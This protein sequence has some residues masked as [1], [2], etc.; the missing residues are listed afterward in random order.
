MQTLAEHPHPIVTVT[1][2]KEADGKGPEGPDTAGQTAEPPADAPAAAVEVKQGFAGMVI[3]GMEFTDKA[4][5]G[6]ALLDACKEIKGT[7]PVKIGS[8]RGFS[9]MVSVEGFGSSVI[10]TLKGQ[11]SHRAELGKDTLGNLARIDHALSKMPERLE[12]VETQLGNLREQL[13]A[14]RAEMG[15]P[16]PM[17]AELKEKSARLAELDSLLNIGGGPPVQE[18]VIAK[19]ARPS[20]LDSL[21]RPLPPRQKAETERPKKH[22]QE[23]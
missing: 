2:E 10:L 3:K 9:M 22:T 14:A 23:R 7:E 5:A 17:E 16:F 13:E 8:Y 21:K 15:K 4:E 20:V 19:S 12:V 6:A 11:M 18:Q 1:K